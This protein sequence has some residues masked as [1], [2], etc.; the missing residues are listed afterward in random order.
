MDSLMEFFPII[1]YT[2]SIIIMVLL[3]VLIVKLIHTV[4]KAN[5]I[6]EDVERKTKSLNGLFHVID[7]VTDTLSVFTDT[8]VSTIVQIFGKILPKRRKK[9]IKKEIDEDE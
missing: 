3:M 9:K 8:A 7:G 5:I 4:D 6:L 1:I 2:L